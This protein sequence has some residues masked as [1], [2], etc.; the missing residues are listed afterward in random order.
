[1]T[2]TL[3]LAMEV[4]RQGAAQQAQVKASSWWPHHR[5]K[6]GEAA[7]VESVRHDKDEGIHAWP[8]AAHQTRHHGPQRQR[9]AHSVHSMTSWW[10][11]PNPK[12]RQSWVPALHPWREFPTDHLNLSLG[13]IQS[14]LDQ[15]FI[16]LKPHNYVTKALQVGD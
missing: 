16:A 9:C 4:G 11:H 2:A 14:V 7:G 15:R 13:E 8:F 5:E 10:A 6:L 1:M 3:H 12:L